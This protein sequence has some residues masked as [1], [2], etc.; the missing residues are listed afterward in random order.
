MAAASDSLDMAKGVSSQFVLLCGVPNDEGEKV[1]ADI[2][3]PIIQLPA[4]TEKLA[5]RCEVREN[6]NQA[7]INGGY[8]GDNP[9]LGTSFLCISPSISVSR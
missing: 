8:A 6:L 9:H 4:I 2:S 3:P 7:P 5:G 1:R